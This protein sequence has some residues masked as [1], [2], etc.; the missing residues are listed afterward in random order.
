MS[1]LGGGVL[2]LLDWAKSLGGDGNAKDVAELLTQKNQV[3]EDMVWQEGNLPTGHRI[4]VRTSLPSPSWRRL[5]EGT[6]STKGTTAQIDE[7]CGMLEDW[8]EVDAKLA[9]MNGDLAGFRMRQAAPHIEGLNQE[10]VQ[11]LFYGNHLTAEKEFTGFAPRYA[12]ISNTE[13]QQMI[14]A[15]AAGSDNTSIYLV[16]WGP[17]HV[18]G[19]FP[20]GSKAG[21]VHEDLGLTTVQTSTSLGGTRMRAYQDRWG[22]DGGLCVEDWRY[23]VRIGSIDVSS[24]VADGAGTSVKLMEYM[25]KAIHRLPSLD[26]IRPVF[27]MGRTVREML[28]IQAMNKANLLLNMGYEE[29]AAKTT[30]R[31]IPLKTCDQILETESLI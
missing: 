25:L 28:D 23:V 20:K 7:H 2:T 9:G 12:T 30:F 4:V 16:G 10:F 21:I 26:G 13:G 11:T 8:S 3:L 5:N 22:W 6:A 18:Y 27:Y 31:G 19:I 29:G 17:S 14:D 24:L 1:T 15:G